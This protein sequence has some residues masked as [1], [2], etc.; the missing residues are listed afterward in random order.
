MS[1]TPDN[2]DVAEA[3]KRGIAV[4]VVPPI[5]AE[6]VADLHIGLMIAVARR[7]IEGDR[8]VRA[9]R[10][11]G[12]QSNHL[13]GSFVHGKTLGLVGG[14]RIG[15]ATARR[16]RGFGM[17]MHLLG[18]RAASRRP[19]ASSAWNTC[20]STSCWRNPISSRCIRRSTPRPGT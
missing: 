5:V 17:R 11:P 15:Q 4:T 10:F 3:T 18:R 14:G 16:A 12:S 13:V 19:S 2:I 20:R 7:M 1:I 6:S 9:G 8:S